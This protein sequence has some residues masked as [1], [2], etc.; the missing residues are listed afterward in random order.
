MNCSGSIENTNLVSGN[1][2]FLALS[3]DSVAGDHTS[4]STISTTVSPGTYLHPVTATAPT[5]VLG[6]GNA[7]PTSLGTTPSMLGTGTTPIFQAKT[8]PLQAPFLASGFLAP[9]LHTGV[10]VTA[11]GLLFPPSAS[12]DVSGGTPNTSWSFSRSGMPIAPTWPHSS[13]TDT[14][15]LTVTAADHARIGSSS[16]V[17]TGSLRTYSASSKVSSGIS[18]TGLASF[19]GAGARTANQVLTWSIATG[20]LIFIQYYSY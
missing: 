13:C 17:P 2:V 11:S 4:T 14:P 6:T 16:T 10:A 8:E 19:T 3:L 1:G 7:S 18:S 9:N 5:V 15:Y 12:G 20:L